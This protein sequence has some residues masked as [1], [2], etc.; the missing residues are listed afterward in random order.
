MELR[1][2]SNNE[3]CSQ[4][5]MTKMYEYKRLWKMCK[6]RE[7]KRWAMYEAITY[8]TFW[9]IHND[10]GS[11]ITVTNHSW[12][13]GAIHLQIESALKVL[14]HVQHYI[15]LKAWKDLE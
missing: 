7:F 4:Q 13:K 2:I 8:E 5:K 12:L 1:V 9:N 10:L 15:L 3:T 11:Q 6:S 14:K